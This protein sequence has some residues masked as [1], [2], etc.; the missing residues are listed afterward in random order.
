MN[1]VF[2]L[3]LTE[4]KLF[5]GW[6]CAE[7]LSNNVVLC[8]VAFLICY[9]LLFW[10][11]CNNCVISAVPVVPMKI[12]VYLTSSIIFISRYKGLVV[13]YMSRVEIN[14]IQL[15]H[16]IWKRWI[17]CTN[18]HIWVYLNWLSVHYIYKYC[19]G[20]SYHLYSTLSHKP[21][22]FKLILQNFFKL[23]LKLV[24]MLA[25]EKPSTLSWRTYTWNS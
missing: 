24:F 19:L 17:S 10:Q 7:P 13:K 14:Y 15:S 22:I 6:F 8:C 25:G 20:N 23:L 4:L 18:R 16:A 3:W 11:Y 2:I 9:C 12:H 21:H 5:L 1:Q